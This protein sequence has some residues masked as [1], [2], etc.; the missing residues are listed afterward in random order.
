[1]DMPIKAIKEYCNATDE[2]DPL[3][4]E[5]LKPFTSLVYCQA[6]NQIQ[7]TTLQTIIFSVILASIQTSAK[8][9]N[10]FTLPKY[11]LQQRRR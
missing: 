3:W 2:S 7:Q 9:M 10:G 4:Y 8:S 6:L 1:M 5:K 11:R